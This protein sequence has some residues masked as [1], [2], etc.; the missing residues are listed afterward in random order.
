M[1]RNEGVVSGRDPE[2]EMRCKLAGN[3]DSGLQFSPA[4]AAPAPRSGPGWAGAGLGLGPNIS[5]AFRP[6]TPAGREGEEGEGRRRQRLRPSYSLRPWYRAKG[7]ALM[8]SQGLH[9]RM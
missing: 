1:Y 8:G 7:T 6:R 2:W 3:E 5:R 9:P 4:A